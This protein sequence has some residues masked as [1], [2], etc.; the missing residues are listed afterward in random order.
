M[1]LGKLTALDMTPLGW[2]GRKTSTQTKAWWDDVSWSR[3]TIIACLILELTA[4]TKNFCDGT[5]ATL[6]QFFVSPENKQ[7]DL[8]KRYRP[9]LDAI[10]HSQWSVSMLFATQPTFLGIL[11]EV[12]WTCSNFKTGMTRTCVWILRVSMVFLELLYQDF[13]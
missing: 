6:W 4:L 12:K 9:R 1:W 11:Q 8:S 5:F 10:E 7:T 13:K 2:L 3:K